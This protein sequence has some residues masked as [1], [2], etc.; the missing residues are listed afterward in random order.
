MRSRTANE[1]DAERQARVLQM[2]P[3]ERVALAM[4]LGEEGLAAYMVMHNV[5][6]ATAIAQI[7]ARRRLGRRVSPSADA[8][9]NVD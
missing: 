7:K 6:R 2:T 4:R 5:T 8:D 1:T 3:A 9:I